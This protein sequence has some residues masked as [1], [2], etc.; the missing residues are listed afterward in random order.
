MTKL[1]TGSLVDQLAASCLDKIQRNKECLVN[2]DSAMI[3]SNPG[4]PFIHVTWPTGTHL[5]MLYPADHEYWPERDA[6]RPF[7]FGLACRVSIVEMTADYIGNYLQP[8]A[9]VPVAMVHYFDGSSLTEVGAE[10]AMKAVNEWRE[11]LLSEWAK[12]AGPQ[13]P[14][15]RLDYKGKPVAEG[16]KVVSIESGWRGVV[17]GFEH[18]RGTGE[19]AKCQHEG[20]WGDLEEDDIQWF[21]PADVVVIRK[22]SLTDG[23]SWA[24]EEDGS[25]VAA[26]HRRKIAGRAEAGSIRADVA[27]VDAEGCAGRLILDLA[28][29][30]EAGAMSRDEA[31]AEYERLRDFCD[32]RPEGF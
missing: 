23:L 28:A 20:Y 13:V 31:T 2:E 5:E 7:L 1:T 8:G 11:K 27:K 22:A 19:L 32:Q 24:I 9:P 21:V 18:H 30:L 16:D 26:D 14:G 25:F 10:A 6:L 3:E 4:V 29:L 15:P 12:P 17:V